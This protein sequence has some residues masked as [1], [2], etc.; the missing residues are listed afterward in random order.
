MI[1]WLAQEWPLPVSLWSTPWD[2]EIWER[3]A[4]VLGRDPYSQWPQLPVE[5]DFMPPGENK[6]MSMGRPFQHY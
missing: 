6:A 1:F 4:E 3:T 2:R 5:A